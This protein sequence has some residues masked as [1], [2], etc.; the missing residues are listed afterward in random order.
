MQLLLIRHGE[1]VRVESDTGVADPELTERGRRQA[2]LLAA[3]LARHERL[4]HLVVSPLRRARETVA[5]IAERFAIEPEVLHELAEFDSNSSSYIPMEEMKATRHPRL[6][7][8]VEG[9]WQDLGGQVE[10]EAFRR[11]ILDTLGRVTEAHPGETVAV[12]CHG[13]VINA[14]LGDVIGT[15]RLLWFEPRYTSIHRVL[16]SRHGIRSVETLNEC[17][18]LAPAGRRPEH[19]GQEPLSY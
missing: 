13:A 7:A 8:L 3:W 6:S 18:H 9:R 15:P 11:T 17:P 12:I 2:D 19:G 10:P 4:D 14:Y 5:P 16:I 1:T